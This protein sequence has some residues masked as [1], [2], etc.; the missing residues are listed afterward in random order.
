MQ[1]A[2]LTLGIAATA[3]VA[4]LVAA[5]RWR[6][7]S[8]V[9]LL[10]GGVV[11]GPSGVGLVQ[12]SSLGSGL[13]A[14]IS[15]AVAVILFEGGLTLDVEGYRRAPQVIRR[16]LTLGPL[17]TW[18]GTAAALMLLFDLDVGMAVMVGSLI[19]VTGPTV[20][21]P[22]LRRIDLP[23]RLHHVLYWEGVLID[24]VGVFIAV[25]CYEWLSPDGPSTLG[26]VGRFGLRIV[27]GL[28][29]G[30]VFG[31]VLAHVLE[32]E[33][34]AREHANIVVLTGALLTFSVANAV[35]HESGILAVIVA[36]LVV[37]IR[38]PPLLRHLRGFKLQLTELG[39]GT[40]FI[41]LSARLD[42]TRFG[43]VRL[44]ALLA[45]VIFVLRPLSVWLATW[46][47]GF[48]AKEKLL[49]SWIAPRGIVAAAMA[50]LFALRLEEFGQANAHLLETVAYAVIAT[51]VT[52]QGLSAGSVARWLGITRADRR[53]W[54]L[55]GEQTL[56]EALARGLRRCGVKTIE[57]SDPETFD[58]N[59][60][61]LVDAGA[62]LCADP[63]GPRS[64]WLG[65]FAHLGIADEMCFRWARGGHADGGEKLP[66]RA[67]WDSAVTAAAFADGL[68]KGS[69]EIAAVELAEESEP[70][71]FGPQL[72]PLFWVADGVPRLVEDP[73]DPGPPQG[74]MAVVVRRRVT[75][76]RDLIAHVEIIDQA[77]PTFEQV[78]RRIIASGARMDPDLPLGELV[79]E[80]LERRQV[81]PT[82]VGGGIAI[83]HAYHGSLPQGRCYLAVVPGGVA[84]MKT[85]DQ[86]PVRLVFLLVSSLGQASEHLTSL[87]ALAEL[88]QAPGFVDLLCRQKVPVRIANLIRER[89]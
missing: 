50:S 19:I 41:L 42:L 58:P 26:S 59:D 5:E 81:M 52:V 57:L 17:I 89:A 72:M 39:I 64:I 73:R 8:I 30:F 77:A 49:L 11:L 69:H 54:A 44:A 56:V 23:E 86:L 13:E 85:P 7:P 46:G 22:L 53:T 62:V 60:P 48:Q 70:G 32:R 38:N 61:R 47:Q 83:P 80:I 29:L 10:F 43:D 12:P 1:D 82:A 66:G 65:L 36:G 45:V 78:L 88:G 14:V 71:R 79:D 21:S 28:G 4:F 74:A 16:M 20:V 55:A 2:T 84:D 37:A 75:G 63:A 35:L 51:T 3:G 6:V 40:L 67:V 76:L 34:V 31:R 87:A 27:T 33:W 68:A 25:L 24:A 15:I 18:L 9:L